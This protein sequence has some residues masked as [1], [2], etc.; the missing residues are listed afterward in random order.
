MSD[1]ATLTFLNESSGINTVPQAQQ[2]AQFAA[3]KG[4]RG[5]THLQH[6]PNAPSVPRCH[7]CDTILAGQK[8]QTWARLCASQGVTARRSGKHVKSERIA[9]R[10]WSVLQRAAYDKPLIPERASKN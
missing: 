5:T 1:N 2:Q 9:S 3:A 6:S 10:N 4:E 8:S 7:L